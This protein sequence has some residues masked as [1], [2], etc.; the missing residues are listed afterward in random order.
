ML[1]VS[2]MMAAT[3]AFDDRSASHSKDMHL[4][5]TPGRSILQCYLKLFLTETKKGQ[6]V[7][8]EMIGR[9]RRITVNSNVFLRYDT[10][11][12]IVQITKI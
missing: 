10:F 1:Y 5:G 2:L 11:N 12:S 7:Y 3:V 6:E 4:G 9:R 8:N